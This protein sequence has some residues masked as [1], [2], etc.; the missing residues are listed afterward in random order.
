MFVYIFLFT[1]SRRHNG[2]SISQQ[3]EQQK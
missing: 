1:T 2:N 3:N